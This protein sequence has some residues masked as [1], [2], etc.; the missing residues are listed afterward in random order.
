MRKQP[1]ITE[2]AEKK[3]GKCITET[4][5]SPVLWNALQT[6]LAQY[7]SLNWVFYDVPVGS[8]QEKMYRWPGSEDEDIMICVRMGNQI[9]EFFHR[10]DYF[11]IKYAYQ[12]KFDVFSY[13][14][15]NELTVHQGECYIGQPFAGYALQGRSCR[16]L[17]LVEV[18][19]RREAFFRTFLPAISANSGLFRFFLAPQMNEFSDEFIH[20]SFGK[21]SYVR[22]LVEMMVIEYANKK[23]DSQELL[24]LLV[25]TM[26]TYAARIYKGQLPPST[27]SRLSDKII[28][29]MNDHTD[30]VSLKEIAAVFSYHPNYI[31][32]V[33]HEETGQTFSQILLKLRME[34]ALTLL[35]GSTL[36]MEEIAYMLG[37]SNSSNFYKAFR[38]YFHTSPAVWREQE[39]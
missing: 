36:T 16:E 9:H 38:E 11:F 8:E 30:A 34:R 18:L 17:I 32:K 15:D 2:K 39:K 22:N 19:I 13:K 4:T 28:R 35:K 21:D 23:A 26:L 33:L 5:A 7:D 6:L 3:N 12:Y 10:Q 14:Y 37:Y 25:L 20:L 27:E 31:S 1:E 24:K 29:Y